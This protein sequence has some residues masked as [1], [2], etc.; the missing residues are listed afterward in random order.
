M[1]RAAITIGIGIGIA[2]GVFAIGL[3]WQE[4]F[5][6][7]SCHCAPVPGLRWHVREVVTAVVGL[8][9]GALY[10]AVSGAVMRSRSAA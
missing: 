7:G 8:A 10:V 9:S 2:I 3:V 6:P 4:V 1:K 5:Y